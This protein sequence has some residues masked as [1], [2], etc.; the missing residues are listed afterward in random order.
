MK[1]N[2]IDIKNELKNLFATFLSQCIKESQNYD[3][4]INSQTSDFEQ[5]LLDIYFIVEKI[6]KNEIFSRSQFCNKKV[7]EIIK[8]LKNVSLNN[9]KAIWTKIVNILDML[10]EIYAYNIQRG[11]QWKI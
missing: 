7:K 10:D 5:K 9:D 6:D 4:Q 8:I 1:K 3:L 2:N 11:Y